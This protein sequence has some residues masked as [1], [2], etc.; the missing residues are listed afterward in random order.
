MHTTGKKIALITWWMLFMIAFSAPSFGEHDHGSDHPDEQKHDA[1][2]EH[3]RGPGPLIEEMVRLDAVF[4][5]VVSGV[6][7]GDGKRVHEAIE[8]M[9]GAMEKTHEGVHHGAVTLGKNAHRLNE[10]IALDKQFHKKLERLSRAAHKNDQPAMV[11]L[12]KQLLE[13]CVQCH[14]DFRKP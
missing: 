8:T 6:A 14:R 7:L 9:H 2:E 5:D 4:R 3:G 13:G 10:F 11:S 1:Q 12:T